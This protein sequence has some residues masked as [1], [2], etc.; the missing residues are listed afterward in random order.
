MFV[1]VSV[2]VPWR[3]CLCSAAARAVASLY[4]LEG[5]DFVQKNHLDNYGDVLTA[6]DVAAIFGISYIKA[7]KL[8]RYHMNHIR[9]GRTYHL[10]KQNLIEFLNCQKSIIIDFD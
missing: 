1:S 4:Y 2:C 7:L 10:S 9:I 6:K 5:S 3:V 8:L